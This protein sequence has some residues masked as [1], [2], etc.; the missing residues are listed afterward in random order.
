VHLL[1]AFTNAVFS[2]ES[3][4]KL[5]RIIKHLLIAFTNAVFSLESNIKLKRIIKQ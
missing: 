2:L 4:I 1:I 3:N 5:K